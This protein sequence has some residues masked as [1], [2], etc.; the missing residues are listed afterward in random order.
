MTGIP[1]AADY[2]L[3]VRGGILA[4]EVR[5]RLQADWADYVFASDYKLLPLKEVEQYIAEKRPPA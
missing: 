2:R 1:N 3:F 5:I 4:E